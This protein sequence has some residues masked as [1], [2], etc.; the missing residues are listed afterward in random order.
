MSRSFIT[1]SFFSLALIVCIAFSA[2]AAGDLSGVKSKNPIK[3]ESDYMKYTGDNRVSK[4]TGNVMVTNGQMRMRADSMD[5]SFDDK[6]QVKE[7]YS[8]GNVKI[9]KE[10][11]LSL[12]DNAKFYNGEN[13]AVLTGNVR[14]WQG[15]NYL[16]GEKVTLYNDSNKVIV[17]RGTNKRVKIIIVPKEDSK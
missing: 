3:I 7:I 10:G 4:F 16:E 6:N 17:D 9:E 2:N 13:K 11:M 8:Q 15:D 5:V 1:N 12:S 14:V